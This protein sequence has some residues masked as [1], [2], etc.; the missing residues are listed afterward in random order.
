MEEEAHTLAARQYKQLRLKIEKAVTFRSEKEG[1][2]EAYFRSGSIADRNKFC[3]CNITSSAIQE[4]VKAALDTSIAVPFELFCL[5]LTTSQIT[6]EECH[7]ITKTFYETSLLTS[8]ELTTSD[9]LCDMSTNCVLR[10][11]FNQSAPIGCDFCL[12]LYKKA[13]KVAQTFAQLVKTIGI[14]CARLQIQK[15]TERV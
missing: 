2:V 15:E 5:S 3:L 6:T 12:L 7:K 4:G 1:P 14:F 10:E 8:L 9:I 13:N 11:T